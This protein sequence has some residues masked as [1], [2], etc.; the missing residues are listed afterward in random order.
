MKN[1]EGFA[2][3]L[4]QTGGLDPEKHQIIASALERDLLK[5]L[6]IGKDKSKSIELD[7]NSLLKDSEAFYIKSKLKKL[8]DI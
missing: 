5:R 4:S 6:N 1:L 3:S 2:A 8:C 7:E